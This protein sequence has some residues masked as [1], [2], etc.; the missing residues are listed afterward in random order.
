LDAAAVRLAART[1][2][3]AVPGDVSD[4]SHRAALAR[5]AAG[6]GPVRLIVNN[7]STLGASP[8]PRLDGIDPD[9]LRRIF[10]VN[11]VAPIALE[12]AE[13][14]PGIMALVTG[15]QPSGRYRAKALVPSAPSQ[16]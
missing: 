6:L 3:V 15:G 5:A 1:D 4:A 12:R 14:V 8:L 2:V 10:D 9:V 7:A 16:P 11:V 13:S